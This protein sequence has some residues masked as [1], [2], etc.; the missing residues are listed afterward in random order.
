[1]SESNSDPRYTMGRSEGETERLIQQS[2]L[3]EAVTL[4]FFQEAGLVSGMRVLD[5]GSGA[6]DVAMAAA[7]LVGAEGEV[8]GVDVNAAILD[9]ARARVKELGFENIQFIAGDARTLD[10]EGEFDA[11]VGR[12]VLMYMSDPADALKE[13]TRRL[14]PGGIVAFQEV[15]FTPYQSNARPDT[16]LM[17]KLVEW[18][19]AVFQHSGAHI[20]MGMDLHRTF[21]DAG[22]PA[23]VLHFVAP[24]GGAEMWAGYDFIANAFRSLVPL[25]EEFGIA[26]AEEV[27][28]DTLSDR[29]REEIRV[30][31]RPLL[32]PPHV[33]AWARLET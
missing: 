28:V 8:V 24:L 6:G 9:T 29:I 20:E 16:P 11:V 2:Q 12:L 32:L 19:I 31:K 22:L 33:T 4:R 3:Y 14:R 1:M 23:P 15:D 7:E 27:D 17:N 5:V 30:S 13:F 18:G 25:M 21:L 10:M 26:T